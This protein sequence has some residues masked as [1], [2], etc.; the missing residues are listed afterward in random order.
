MIEGAGTRVRTVL[1]TRAEA[2]QALAKRLLEKEVLEGE[3]LEQLLGER[4]TGD[5]LAGP[6]ARASARLI[7]RS[8]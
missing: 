6:L 2:L 7:G 4:E 5:V 8:S 3:E 1:T